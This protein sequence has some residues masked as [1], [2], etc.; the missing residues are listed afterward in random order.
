MQGA[1]RD[2]SDLILLNRDGETRAQV[3]DMLYGPANGA[4]ALIDGANTVAIGES[5]YSEWLRAAGDSVLTLQIPTGGRV[6]VFAPDGSAKYDSSVDKGDVFV[7]GGDYVEVSGVR[8][9]QFRI[10][11]EAAYRWP[12]AISPYHSASPMGA[13][14]MAGSRIFSDW[15]KE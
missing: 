12:D 4:A 15:A 5:G 6:I 9:D 13:I 1:T 8:G 14:F 3:L 10:V 7:N 11:C 2:L